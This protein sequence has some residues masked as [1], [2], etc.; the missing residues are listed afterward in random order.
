M[1]IK[2]RSLLEELRREVDIQKKKEVETIKDEMRILKDIFKSKIEAEISSVKEKE[3][4][5]E[6]WDKEHDEGLRKYLTK[7]LNEFNKGGSSS[8]GSESEEE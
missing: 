1:E 7:Y 5:K 8:A 3:L 4:D 2:K 6:L